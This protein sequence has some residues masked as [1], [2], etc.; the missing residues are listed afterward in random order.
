MITT[1]D[2][3]NFFT[4]KEH[5]PILSEFSNHFN[6]QLK[7]VDTENNSLLSLE[8]L[9]KALCDSKFNQNKQQYEKIK[10]NKC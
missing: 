4:S 6:A 1:S 2:D 10:K 8:E 9:S 3:R 5:L 7:V